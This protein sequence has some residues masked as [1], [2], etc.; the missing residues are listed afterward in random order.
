MKRKTNV[1]DWLDNQGGARQQRDMVE[2]VGSTTECSET[3][4]GEVRCRRLRM[5]Y[6]DCSKGDTANDFPCN[7]LVGHVLM[8]A[9]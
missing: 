1:L 6:L 5:R 3:G 8:E 7:R 2:T 9:N 4:G